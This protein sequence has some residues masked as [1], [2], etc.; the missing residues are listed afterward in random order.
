MK[1]IIP[2]VAAT[3]T[4]YKT[5]FTYT[6]PEGFN[7]NNITLVGVVQK[8][9]TASTAKEVLNAN[10]VGLVKSIAKTETVL[11]NPYL[12]IA[13]NNEGNSAIT[14]K[15]LG[16]ASATVRLEIDTEN[17][18]IPE[19]WTASLE[20]SSCFGSWRKCFCKCKN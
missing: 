8:Y 2:A 16:S 18:I 15:N 1:G 12:S 9:G 11:P 6:L 17:S 3:A 5:T 19:G 4:P 14:V 13:K 7:E 10:E 20:P